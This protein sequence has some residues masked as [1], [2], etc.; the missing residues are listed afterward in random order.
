MSKQV[1]EADDGGADMT[2]YRIRAEV[3]WIE[4]EVATQSPT[5]AP[6]VRRMG[7]FNYVTPVSPGPGAATSKFRVRLQDPGSSASVRARLTRLSARIPLDCEP[8]VVGV[9]V[10]LDAY[11]RNGAH[12]D[13]VEMAARLF[14]HLTTLVSKNRRFSGRWKGDVLALYSAAETLRLLRQDR[15]IFVGDAGASLTQRIYVKCQD[16]GEVLD[17]QEQRA[18]LEVTMRDEALTARS[19]ADWGAF[20]FQSLATYFRFRKQRAGLDPVVAHALQRAVQI[21]ERKNRPRA[22]GGTRMYGL[23]SA[24][25]TRLNKA[26]RDALRELSRRWAGPLRST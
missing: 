10:S 12:D 14:K 11:S 18:R 1:A 19:L 26:A 17:V 13:L 25:D 22:G 5:N 7:A 2:K 15:V 3:D 20:P 8:T 9:E 21:G 23:G 6:T 24:A 4:C 16:S